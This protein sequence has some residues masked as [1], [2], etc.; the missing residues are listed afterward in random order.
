[1]RRWDHS[2]KS[3]VRRDCLS[4]GRY[5]TTSVTKV[6][7]EYIRF[8]K[9]ELS[10]MGRFIE[11]KSLILTR[12]QSLIRTTYNT[13]FVTRG[14]IHNENHRFHFGWSTRRTESK[15]TGC[16]ACKYIFCCLLYVA[17]DFESSVVRF[18]HS[19]VSVIVLLVVTYCMCSPSCADFG[20]GL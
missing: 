13:C 11:R 20:I 6:T 2:T 17:V 15:L 3:Q 1:M 16:S 9:N 5:S 19:G 4:L 14:R 18:L 10:S 7:Q 8:N 12:L